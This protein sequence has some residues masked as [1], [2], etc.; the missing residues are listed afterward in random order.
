MI[1]SILRAGIPLHEGVLEVFDGAD[2]AFIGAYRRHHKSGEFEI[3]LDYISSIS[4]EGRDLILCD[5]MLATG[6]SILEAIRSLTQASR[7]K[8]IHI[9]SIISSAEGVEFIEKNVDN[10]TLWTAAIDEEL[11]AKGYIVPGLGDAGDLAYGEKQ[12]N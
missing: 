6:A 4:L 7:P 12:Q 1:G 10:F 3:K 8:H 5:P 2:N 9:V 11:T